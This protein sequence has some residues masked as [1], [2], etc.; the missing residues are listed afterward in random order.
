M[1]L[2]DGGNYA[3]DDTKN[4]HITSSEDTHLLRSSSYE[5]I[6]VGTKLPGDEPTDCKDELV[7]VSDVGDRFETQSSYAALQK[8]SGGMKSSSFENLYEMQDRQVEERDLAEMESDSLHASMREWQMKDS[9]EDMSDRDVMLA[10]V[11]SRLWQVRRSCPIDI[12]VESGLDRVG[13][14]A[15][16]GSSMMKRSYCHLLQHSMSYDVEMDKKTQQQHHHKA[17]SGSSP[18]SDDDQ[19]DFQRGRITSG[20][21]N[22]CRC[23][24]YQ[25]RLLLSVLCCESNALVAL[26]D[27]N[28]FIRSICSF[29]LVIC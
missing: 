5:D 12:T 27:A 10:P 28:H 22:G 1:E 2:L 7:N 26:F 16:H 11:S 21:R 17:S 29:V 14:S 3:K 13:Q 24:M 9:S 8:Q 4:N 25:Y 23:T 6:Y 18:D 19:M 15:G 20:I